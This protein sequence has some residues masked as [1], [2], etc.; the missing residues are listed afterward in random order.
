MLLFCDFNESDGLGICTESLCSSFWLSS[1]QG[2]PGAAAVL[3]RWEVSGIA[4]GKG[5][6]HIAAGKHFSF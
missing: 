3:G 6:Y 2:F 1:S 5:V 4:M